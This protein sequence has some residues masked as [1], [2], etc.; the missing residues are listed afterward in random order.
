MTVLSKKECDS[1]LKSL[2]QMA[3]TTLDEKA[4]FLD[5]QYD[6]FCGLISKLTSGEGLV[7][8]TVFARISYLG[9]KYRLKK[10]ILNDLHIYRKEYDKKKNIAADILFDIGKH[11]LKELLKLAGLRNLGNNISL[12]KRPD[13]QIKS[14]EIVKKKLHGRYNLISKKNSEEYIVVD[15]DDPTL[16]LVMR[17]D[18]LE[19]FKNAIDYINHKIETGDVLVVISLVYIEY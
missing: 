7:F 8:N 19:T 14:N 16:E 13:Y 17:V 18:N 6:I 3:E 5:Y 10:D 15:D 12:I 11:N 4:G 9:I 1:Y 2:N